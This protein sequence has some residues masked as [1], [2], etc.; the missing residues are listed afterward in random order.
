MTAL[1]DAAAAW[2]EEV[3]PHPRHLTRS[4][5]Y[6]DELQPRAREALRIATVTHDSERAFPDPDPPFDSARHFDV[7][8][9]LR[10]HQRRSAAMVGRWL[11]DRGA[12]F[13][14]RDDVATLVAV[15]E[16][17]GWAEADLLQAADS[18]SFLETMVG[19]VEGWITSGRTAP[20]RAFAKLQ[21]MHDRVSPDLP[22]AREL[23]VPLLAGGH[24]RLRDVVG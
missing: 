24:A 7:P 1:V 2:M 23:A 5:E 4:L 12:A 6:L 18:L 22:R 21:W 14:L 9:Y 8:G 10:F 17:G 3:H 19:L 20:E 16:E 15:H 13:R 11:D